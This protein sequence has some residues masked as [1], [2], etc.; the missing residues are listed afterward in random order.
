MVVEPE[1]RSCVTWLQCPYNWPILPLRLSKAV[2][3]TFLHLT[4]S[5]V[6]SCETCIQSRKCKFRI[7]L[8]VLSV[9]HGVAGKGQCCLKMGLTQILHKYDPFSSVL[10]PSV[11]LMFISAFFISTRYLTV[12]RW[13]SPAAK[14]KGTF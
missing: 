5:D 11:S 4:V 9:T 10:T 3:W 12:F 8:F 14:C 13:P 7:Q 1:N 6:T 2:A